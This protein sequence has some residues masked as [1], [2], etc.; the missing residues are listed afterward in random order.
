MSAAELSLFALLAVIVV[1]L[2]SRINIGV[3][4]IALASA[5]AIMAAGWTPNQVMAE[6]PSGL[7][8]TL[9]GIT[10]MFGVA[11]KNGTLEGLTTR[12]VRL[13]GAWVALIPISFFLLAGVLSAAGPGAIVATAL[14]VPLAM[15][16]GVRAGIP[17]FLIA[18]MVANGANAGNLSYLS[19]VGRIVLEQMNGTGLGGY[20]A[21]VFLANF[22]AHTAVAIAAYLLFGGLKLLRAGR[23]EMSEA[24]PKPF[25]G[26]Q[27]FTMAV[28]GAWIIGVVYFELNP[29]VSAF[30]AAA[31]LIIGRATDN[32]SAIASV[33]WGIIL[34]VSGV[35]VLIGVMDEIGGLDRFTELLAGIATPGT[36]NGVMAFVTGIISTYSSTSG[37]VYPA[38][39]P[40]V[41]GLVEQLG[42]GDP[43]EISLSINVGAALVDVSPLSTLGAL[44]LAALPQGAEDPAVL[45]RKMLIWGFSM[46][47]VG[48]LFC[49]LFIGFFTF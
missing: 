22:V 36:A 2:T 12:G 26:T 39:L 16:A 31:V 29:G 48:A 40:T 28:L 34:M 25:S 44:C 41:P 7:F 15:V 13:C 24:N 1:S 42:G 9:V 23:A 19:A 11:Q 35:S 37:V 4:A 18:L 5:V 21:N 43:L 46:S 6:F 8:L 10:L 30:V 45:F 27:W 14:V 33:P 49:Q 20:E 47:V 17:V 3:L 32:S 38:F